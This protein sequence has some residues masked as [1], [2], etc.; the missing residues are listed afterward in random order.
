MSTN[1]CTAFMHYSK[2]KVF[3]P[4]PLLYFSLIWYQWY[5]NVL[6]G[7]LS[8]GLALFE[9]LCLIFVR[10]CFVLCYCMDCFGRYGLGKGSHTHMYVGRY[11]KCAFAYGKFD[12]TDVT[13]CGRQDIK[14]QL[15]TSLSIYL[16]KR[17]VSNTVI[18]KKR[19]KKRKKLHLFT[20]KSIASEM[21]SPVSADFTDS[22]IALHGN[23]RGIVS[24][25]GL[26]WAVTLQR[27]EL[28]YMETLGILLQKVVSNEWWLYRE[29]WFT[30][31]LEE[32]CF[33]KW[34]PVSGDFTESWIAL[35]GTLRSIATESGLRRVVSSRWSFVRG[36]LCQN[37]VCCL[38]KTVVLLHCL[39]PGP[40][41]LLWLPLFYFWV[42][43]F[44][45]HFVLVNRTFMYDIVEIIIY[46]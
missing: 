38:F 46:S 31:N 37:D 40:V 22:W 35:H 11:V 29:C 33:R 12:L 42:C 15:L 26:Q 28:L 36:F 9:L 34:S 32:Y 19:K 16:M 30:W 24:E 44:L 4:I 13:L 10:V 43:W 20:W 41:Y 7:A 25:S 1:E 39:F 14:I 23:L 17:E 18:K 2:K 5:Q 21:W 3:L 45:T 8:K 6:T 27:V